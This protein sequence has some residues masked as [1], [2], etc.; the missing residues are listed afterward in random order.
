MNALPLE[1]PRVS[2]DAADPEADQGR[3]SPARIAEP[4]PAAEIRAWARHASFSNGFSDGD[5]ES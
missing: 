2:L 4:S 5:V 3:R 1:H